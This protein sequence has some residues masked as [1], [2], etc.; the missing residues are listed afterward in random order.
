MRG[1]DLF[2]V[3]SVAAASAVGDICWT[4]T[5]N[6]RYGQTCRVLQSSA[7][8]QDVNGEEVRTR[9]VELAWRKSRQCAGEYCAFTNPALGGG[10]VAVTSSVNVPTIADFPSNDNFPAES[11]PFYETPI[12]GKGS[13][14]VANR[15][16]RKGEIIMI[17][18]AYMLVQ[19]GAHRHLDT[20]TRA[21][22]YE[23]AQAELPAER[24][25]QVMLQVGDTIADKVDRNAFQMVIRDNDNAA[26]HLACFHQVGKMNHDCRPKYVCSSEANLLIIVT[27]PTYRDSKRTIS[28]QGPHA[29]HG[30]RP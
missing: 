9:A 16:I 1:L 4:T 24:G 29:H 20:E 13:G 3:V 11:P 8:V 28:H 15:T 25:E 26:S 10:S 23:M 6:S 18:P 2:S 22:L 30:C 7:A 27:S 5:F 12:Q 21:S 17:R 14:L 19:E